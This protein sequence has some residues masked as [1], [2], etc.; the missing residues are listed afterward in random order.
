MYIDKEIKKIHFYNFIM[1]YSQF[2]LK[3]FYK[4]DLN[5]NW[6]KNKFFMQIWIKI[7]YECKKNLIIKI[8]YNFLLD[9]DILKISTFKISLIKL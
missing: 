2:I 8:R 6:M 5:N 7:K 3:K 9:L 1:V 4:L